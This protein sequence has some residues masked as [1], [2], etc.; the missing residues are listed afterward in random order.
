MKAYMTT[1]TLGFLEK[2][3]EKHHKLTF[4]LMTRHRST[5]A[6]YEDAHT[7]VFNSGRA[8]DVLIQ[9]GVLSEN[10]Y[11]VMNHIPATEEGK[12]VFESRLKKRENDI[13]LLKGLQAFRLLKPTKNNTYVILTQWESAEDYEAW[14][15][16][17]DY[18]KS[19]ENQAVKQPAYFASRPYVTTYHMYDEDDENLE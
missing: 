17:E 14:C 18:Q 15:E 9:K 16:T 5:L 12:P 3:A 11:V 7:N 4:S 19:L 8:Y 6:Y 10:G 2:I 1:G 13:V